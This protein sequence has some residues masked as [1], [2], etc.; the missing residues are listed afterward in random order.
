MCTEQRHC[1][2]GTAIR[3][4]TRERYPD[5]RTVSAEEVLGAMIATHFEWNGL[6]ILKTASAALEQ[7]NFHDECALVEQMIRNVQRRFTH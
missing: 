4:T 5:V 1:P 3:N 2:L 6:S 7:A